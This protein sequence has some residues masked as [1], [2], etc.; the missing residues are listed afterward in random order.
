MALASDEFQVANS[1]IPL[2]SPGFETRHNQPQQECKTRST[3]CRYDPRVRKPMKSAENAQRY[4]PECQSS[5]DKPQDLSQQF[6]FSRLRRICSLSC[7][8]L[9][10]WIVS[11]LHQYPLSPESFCGHK[12]SSPAAPIELI[13]H[14]K[15]LTNQ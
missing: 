2:F 14:D 3:G 8:T 9:K 11:F 13:G 7:P 5:R 4:G 1:R 15:A 10:K 12:N 6:A